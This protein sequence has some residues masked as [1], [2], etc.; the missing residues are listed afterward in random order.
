MAIIGYAA[1]I[2]ALKDVHDI[3]ME[4]FVRRFDPELH[5]AIMESDDQ[6]DR[7]F[8]SRCRHMHFGKQLHE[9]PLAAFAETV[10][11]RESVTILYLDARGHHYL[12]HPS[13]LPW[14]MTERDRTATR[15][16]IESICTRYVN[17]IAYRPMRLEFSKTIFN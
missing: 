10:S 16:L 7:G 8:A 15:Q 14:E 17:Q 4:E 5:A 3:L 9:H 13:Q 1:E 12:V 6:P 11:R 2:D